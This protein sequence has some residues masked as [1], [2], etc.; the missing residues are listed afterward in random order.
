MQLALRLDLSGRLP[1]P[2]AIDRE[3]AHDPRE[4]LARDRVL[5]DRGFLE[6]SARVRPAADLARADVALVGRRLR[7]WAKQRVV[8]ALRVGLD[9]AAEAVE[10][11]ADNGARLFRRVLEEHVITVGDLDEVM[12]ARA[13][14]ALLVARADRLDKYAGCVGRNAERVGQRV[15]AHRGNDGRADRHAEILEP[16]R[17]RPAVVRCAE[18]REAIFL[19]VQRQAI[20]QLV[21]RDMREQ[22][23]RRETAREQLRRSLGGGERVGIAAADLVLDT[24]DAEPD[25]ASAAPHQLVRIL[26][27]G[28]GSRAFERGIRQ[29]DAL[30]G[31]V[32]VGEL[33]AARRPLL[34]LAG[35]PRV[36]VVSLIVGTRQ[37]PREQVELVQLGRE[38][39]L[40]LLRVDALGLGDHESAPRDLDLELQMAIALT[41]AIALGAR[42]RGRPRD[43][44]R[45][46]QGLR[47]SP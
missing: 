37:A 7:G 44:R 11:L 12:T 4:P 32:E 14:A 28:A 36:R 15:S 46:P 10:E 18:A 16:T 42:W 45:A 5:R 3:D 43:Q 29:L 41:Q 8:D 24:R 13:C 20:A 1:T 38:L 47:S 40:D 21:A 39:E 31:Q 27:T 33:A 35:R 25:A 22:R 2:R 9:E 34:G 19:P 17:H 23:R 6:L 26:G 30:L